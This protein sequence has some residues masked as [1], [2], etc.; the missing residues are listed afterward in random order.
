MYDFDEIN[1]VLSDIAGEMRDGHV[2]CT[3]QQSA[4]LETTVALLP[5][6]IHALWE[7]LDDGRGVTVGASG[8]SNSIV[9]TPTEDGRFIIRR[10]G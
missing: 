8:A 7:L 3:G 6:F 9:I 4:A 5:L 1:A 2:T 10:A